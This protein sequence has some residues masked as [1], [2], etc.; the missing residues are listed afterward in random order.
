MSIK[1][2]E[3]VTCTHCQKESRQEIW[4]SI[5]TAMYPEM[6]E[7]VRNGSVF[8]FTCPHCGENS[9]IDYGFLYHQAEDHLMIHFVS[10][11]ESFKD[12]LRTY[13]IAR[14]NHMIMK[15]E[16]FDYTIR[17]VHSKEQLLE[18][19]KIFDAGF[20]D[21][22]IELQKLIS[23]TKADFKGQIINLTSCFLIRHNEK[24]AFKVIA[25]DNDEKIVDFDADLYKN[26][27]SGYLGA[28]VDAFCKNDFIIDYH[29]ASRF[30]R[31]LTNTTTR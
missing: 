14:D 3:T 12:I 1:S 31:T 22:I 24:L 15:L 2:I 16:D 19:L 8:H 10:D 11:H 25:E 7:A 9:D 28:R 30:F 27:K 20:D 18:K 23:S 4:N 17:I 26:L 13:N 29:W 6:R 21:R 5:N